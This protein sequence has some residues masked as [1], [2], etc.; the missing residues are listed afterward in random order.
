MK[1]R[2]T[3]RIQTLSSCGED[4]ASVHAL[5]YRVAKSN[6]SR[7]DI[8]ILSVKTGE[9]R[10]CSLTAKTFLP[11]VFRNEKKQKNLAKR[12]VFHRKKKSLKKTFFTSSEVINNYNQ[13]RKRIITFFP[14]LTCP[15]S[16][17]HYSHQPP[18][19]PITVS[20]LE[21][22]LHRSL[23]KMPQTHWY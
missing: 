6:F 19:L 16:E 23:V 2:A 17:G 4:T 12:P 5:S 15:H 11:P 10:F 8:L 3:G 1:Q 20:A 21:E 14:F 18:S 7:D 9:K 13:T 22:A